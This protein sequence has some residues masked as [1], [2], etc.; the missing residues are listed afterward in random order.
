MIFGSSHIRLVLSGAILHHH[1]H[2]NNI[3]KQKHQN[4]YSIGSNTYK[5]WTY[6]HHPCLSD[7]CSGASV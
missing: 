3:N 1:P 7:L 2:K 6:L 5:A 4:A